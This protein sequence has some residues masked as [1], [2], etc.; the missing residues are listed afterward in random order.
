MKIVLLIIGLV[1]LV[2]SV[3][4]VINKNTRVYGII[5]VLLSFML[6]IWGFS[7]VIVPSGYVGI[8]TSY[9]QI[10]GEVLPSGQY[11]SLPIIYHVDKIN[12]KQQ[13][14]NYVGERVLKEPQFMQKTLESVFRL[15]QKK[16]LGFGLTLKSG[17]TNC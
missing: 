6:L 7:I 12:C 3:S 11:F 5:G 1:I 4:G 17:I 14:A 13:D 16:L 9:G 8:K 10:S 15:I 2:A